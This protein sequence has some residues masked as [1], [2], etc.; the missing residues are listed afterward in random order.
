[1]TGSVWIAFQE[2]GAGKRLRTGDFET[3]ATRLKFPHNKRAATRFPM[4]V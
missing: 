2:V 3:T 4:E 1:M